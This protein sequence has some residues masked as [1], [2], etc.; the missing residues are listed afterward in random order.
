MFT[1]LKKPP[2]GWEA[3]SSLTRLNLSPANQLYLVRND[4]DWKNNDGE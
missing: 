4:E 2:V 1:A 3:F